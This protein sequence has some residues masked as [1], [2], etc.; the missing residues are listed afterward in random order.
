MP[1]S[2]TAR[3]RAQR[4][5][6]PTWLL[7]A[8][9]ITAMAIMV[10]T[11]FAP[12]V[13]PQLRIYQR[14][15]FIVAASILMGS[16]GATATVKFRLV[17][18]TGA[19]GVMFGLLYFFGQPYPYIRGAIGNP[20]RARDL[21][22]STATR[23]LLTNAPYLNAPYRFM[24]E[25]HEINTPDFYIAFHPAD[26]DTQVII[27]CIP[28][29]ILLRALGDPNGID[30]ML[31]RDNET[32]ALLN[33]RTNKPIGVVGSSSCSAGDSSNTAADN[34][35]YSRTL[36]SLL[37]LTDVEAQVIQPLD[38]AN[39]ARIING[40]SAPELQTQVAARNALQQI[41]GLPNYRDLLQRWNVKRS[42]YSLDIG[43]LQGW[44]GGI[45]QN[46][47]EAGALGNSLSVGQMYYVTQLAGHPD[48]AIRKSAVEILAWLL[49]STTWSAGRESGSKLTNKQIT[50]QSAQ[51]LI[52]VI[53]SVIEAGPEIEWTE[54]AYFQFDRALVVTGV[55]QAVQMT[56]CQLKPD[57]RASI[58]NAID[59][60]GRGGKYPM[61]LIDA[62]INARAQSIR[63]RMA[64]R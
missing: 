3:G 27:G 61:G 31:R 7:V 9:L 37:G 24:I 36:E 12:K 10:G 8:S 33:A 32:W 49:Q 1:P 14:L 57:A 35:K 13:D 11:V 45:H 19:A 44:I 52:R 59:R 56:Q 58:L 51:D 17:S 20:D 21:V 53:S 40:L 16:I 43:L 25:D 23:I 5:G 2:S 26:A 22:M 18:A 64:C 39:N 46:R 50:Y 47:E 54:P 6:P 55:L 30:F 41:R 42:T 38:A 63:D 48:S 34:A 62:K 60:L 4:S 29:E 28:S 15:M